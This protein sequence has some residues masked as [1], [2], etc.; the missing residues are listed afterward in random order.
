M[1]QLRTLTTI[2]IVEQGMP[3]V[4]KTL[5]YKMWEKAHT[6][7]VTQE[8]PMMTQ[9]LLRLPIARCKEMF[10]IMMLPDNYENPPFEELIKACRKCVGE[11]PVNTL[12]EEEH[13]EELKHMMLPNSWKYCELYEVR[14]LPIDS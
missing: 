4:D 3:A 6:P 14:V 8:V 9:A 12:L 2:D 5:M 13:R 7:D 1:A 11:H 10:R